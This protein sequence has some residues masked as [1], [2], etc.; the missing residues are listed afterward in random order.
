MQHVAHA[1]LFIKKI[2]LVYNLTLRHNNYLSRVC[3][4]NFAHPTALPPI[5]IDVKRVAASKP[6]VLGMVANK[7]FVPEKSQYVNSTKEVEP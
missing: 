5:G 4:I 6:Q 3:K 7:G 1:D 2:L